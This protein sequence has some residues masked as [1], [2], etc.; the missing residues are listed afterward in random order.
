MEGDPRGLGVTSLRGVLMPGICSVTVSL[1]DA[2]GFG[3]TPVQT[4]L[5]LCASPSSEPANPSWSPGNRG[6]LWRYGVA[7]LTTSHLEVMHIWIMTPGRAV[8]AMGSVRPLPGQ[9]PWELPLWDP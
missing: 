7:E 4:L 3:V 1:G 9:G 2:G 6:C 8:S 5:Q